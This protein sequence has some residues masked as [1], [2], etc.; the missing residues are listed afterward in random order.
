[1]L[2]KWTHV[3]D[4]SPSSPKNSS[5]IYTFW[6]G[7]MNFGLRN[8]WLWWI[9]IK[10][11]GIKKV[12]FRRLNA[13]RGSVF[14]PDPPPPKKKKATKTTKNP[15]NLWLDVQKKGQPS[16]PFQH[17]FINCFGIRS[18]FSFGFRS[19]QS[20]LRPIIIIFHSLPP[21]SLVE[22]RGCWTGWRAVVL[23]MMDFTTKKSVNTC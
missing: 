5:L 4:P 6:C 17:Q 12:P 14:G 19:G 22:T 11:I 13:C 20:T 3:A 8:I 2:W 16:P 15:P 1:M 10:M 18:N 9:W 23:L 21:V 7:Y